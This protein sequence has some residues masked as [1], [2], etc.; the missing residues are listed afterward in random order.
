MEWDVMGFANI[1]KSPF[2]V[3][4]AAYPCKNNWEEYTA[5]PDTFEDGSPKVNIATGLIKAKRVPAGFLRLKRSCLEQYRKHYH[6]KY[7]CDNSV[8]P[9]NPDK[10]YTSFFECETIGHNRYGEDVLFCKRWA[11]MGG[12]IWIEPRITISH[13]GIKAWTGN[14]HNYLHSLAGKPNPFNLE[15]QLLTLEIDRIST[16]LRNNLKEMEIAK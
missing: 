13:Y 2:E 5:I 10:K 8:E 1:L 12:E 3:T 14:Y 11:E 15:K 4:G 6:D 7:Y 9:H 16:S